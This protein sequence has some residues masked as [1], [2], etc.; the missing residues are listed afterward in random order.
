MVRDPWSD[1]YKP[2]A[3]WPNAGYRSYEAYSFDPGDDTRTYDAFPVGDVKV[4]F[5]ARGVNFY[6]DKLP[7]YDPVN[8]VSK[9][10]D[11]N[12]FEIR[13]TYKNFSAGNVTV[14]GFG[15]HESLKSP[16][17]KS[18]FTCGVTV[19]DGNNKVSLF[20]GGANGYAN[21]V[22]LTALNWDNFTATNCHVQVGYTGPFIT[23]KFSVT[24]DSNG[25]S[26]ISFSASGT[27][28]HKQVSY[29][30]GPTALPKDSVVSTAD[31]VK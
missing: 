22:D 21:A 1:N 15:L 5:K 13:S 23:G 18:T 16:T 19:K 11:W 2:S 3:T 20:F 9:T 7:A 14:G 28:N 31:G 26:K 10:V 30:I 29:G 17:P 6:S 24:T 4:G 25:K 8:Q 27:V 12:N